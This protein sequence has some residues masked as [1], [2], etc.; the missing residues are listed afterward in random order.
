MSTSV[1]F[2]CS[3]CGRHIIQICGPDPATTFHLC[4]ACLALPG[5]HNDPELRQRLDPDGPDGPEN[6][7]TGRQP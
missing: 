1:E 2:R 4:A 6:N 5:W 3:E 7:Q